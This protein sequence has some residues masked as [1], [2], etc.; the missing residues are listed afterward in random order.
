MDLFFSYDET[1]WMS[2]ILKYVKLVK[3]RNY[4]YNCVASFDIETTQIP[5]INVEGEPTLCSEYYTLELQE[6][7]NIPVSFMWHW[8]F[9][10]YFG[11]DLYTVTGRKWEEFLKF[12]ENLKKV[13]Y[14]GKNRYLVIYVHNL[15]Y[16]FQYIQDF[17]EWT[18]I[19]ARQPRRIMKAVT[20]GLEF[21]CSYYLSN[22]NLKK[23]CETTK[24]VEHQKKDGDLD[25]RVYRDYDS[26]LTKEEW[27]YC[28]NDVMGLC[29]AVWNR[30]SDY[31]DTIVS[32]P[33]TSTGYVRREVRK[34]C[35]E[36]GGYKY[37]KKIKMGFPNADV[38]LLSR[39]VFRGGDTHA[40]YIKANRMITNVHSF[41]IKSSYPACMIYEK[42]PMGKAV[43]YI[44]P[45]LDRL[46]ELMEEKLL[47]MEIDIF[48]LELMSD[49]VMPYIDFAHVKGY[50]NVE[51]D[52]GRILNAEYVHYA[53]TSIDLK[54]IINEYSFSQL[55]VTKCYGWDKDYLPAEI[56]ESTIEYFRRKTELDGLNEYY[57]EYVKRKNSI[58]SIY[59]MMVTPYD[60]DDVIY[61]PDT[62]SWN[63]TKNELEVLLNKVEKSYNTFLLYQWGVFITSYARYNLHLMLDKVKRDAVYI[64]TDS[65][66]FI[67]EW[68]KVDFEEKNK[69]IMELALKNNAYATRPDGKV[70]YIG[71]W[72]YEGIYDEFKT[73]GAKKYCVKKNGEYII[74]V[75]GMN[76]KKGSAKI[77][78]MEDFSI[79]KVFEDVGRT[80]S[81]YNDNEPFY[82]LLKGKKILITPN[83]GI[84][85]TTYTLGIT[86]EYWELL[87]KA[88]NELD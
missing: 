4:Y 71:L 63:V 84:L 16:E 58:N 20:E 14:L 24:N 55:N 65:I 85:D 6:Y 9:C 87:L 18:S 36:N 48:D 38:Y 12:V 40:S 49:F 46:L 57:Y 26:V 42:F 50:K 30:M 25:Y 17:F 21:R 2:N 37:R 27:E 74:T 68:H 54:I 29:E 67:G 53:C 72:E 66:K 43:E 5:Y 59:G 78:S 41:D 31:N 8:Q 52:N 23:F 35:F 10:V 44:I 81:W 62:N 61:I 1:E 11:G 79:G 88:L 73:L 83:V 51:R 28:V 15:A 39:K 70:E 33:L 22:M 76:K 60:M 45:D 56:R 7:V 3:K 75:S 80:T 69:E 47:V 77:K 82:T 32:I 86:D 34:N 13:L 64:D 19:F